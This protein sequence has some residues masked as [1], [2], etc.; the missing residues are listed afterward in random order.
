ME[1]PGWADR[2]ISDGGG[3]LVIGATWVIA[4]MGRIKPRREEP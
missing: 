4:A 3:A 1:F 2:L